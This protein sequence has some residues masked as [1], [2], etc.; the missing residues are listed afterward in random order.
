VSRAKRF[1]HCFFNRRELRL[2]AVLLPFLVA[3]FLISLSDN[4][5]AIMGCIVGGVFLLVGL[6][7]AG[8]T[9]W[10]RFT[11]CVTEGIVVAHVAD[12]GGGFL[13]SVE[14]SDGHGVTR[15]ETA[16]E[17]CD[18]WGRPAVGSRVKVWYSPG[19][20]LG[21]QVVR[22]SRWS[23]A[24]LTG[25]IGAVTLLLCLKP[26]YEQ[27]LVPPIVGAGFLLFF[28]GCSHPTLRMRFTGRVVS[29]T[30]VAGEPCRGRGST[31]LVEFRD[32]DGRGHR[33]P[34]LCVRSA[35]RPAGGSR[36]KVWYDPRGRRSCEL[37]EW[38]NWIVPLFAGVLGTAI[39]VGGLVLQRR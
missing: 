11:G 23:F 9:L 4:A 5:G 25:G 12:P 28:F 30:V 26:S 19:G 13:P 35:R 24:L 15:R 37:V 10:V 1:L 32:R 14:F 31:L 39:L 38:P 6:V 29:G 34:A 33:E 16:D 27:A 22:G 18:A 17:G 7:W 3:I 21:C 20:R 8:Q 2:A 36:V